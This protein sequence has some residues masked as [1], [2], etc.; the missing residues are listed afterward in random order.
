MKKFLLIIL[1][2]FVCLNKGNAQLM[3]A[4]TTDKSYEINVKLFPYKNQKLFIASYFGSMCLIIDSAQLDE[5]SQCVF[6]GTRKLQSGVY[7]LCDQNKYGVIDFLIGD[8]PFFTVNAD[9][10]DTR[11]PLIMYSN[12]TDNSRLADY[13]FFIKNKI[14]EFQMA[15][16]QL[17][18][19]TNQNEIAYIQTRL[20]G[21]NEE[22]KAKKISTLNEDPQSFVSKMLMAMYEPTL[23]DELQIQKN[24]KDSTKAKQYLSDHF[25]DGVDFW[26]TRLAYTPFFLPKVKKYFREIVSYKTDTI[27]KKIDWML[28]YAAASEDMTQLLLNDFI[29]ASMNHS[30]RWNDSVLIHLYEKYIGPKKYSWL[31]EGEV[32]EISQKAFYLMGKMIGSQ[33]PDIELKNLDDQL[34]SLYRTDSKFTILAFWDPTCHHCR[35]TLPKLDSMYRSTWKSKGV[36]VF[37]FAS[38]SDGKKVDWTNYIGEHHLENW[39]NVYCSN[40][41][42]ASQYNLGKKSYAQLYDV[43]YYPS[44]FVLDKAKRFVAKK[45]NYPQL[46][47]FLKTYLKQ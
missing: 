40:D 23:P 4:G 6:T 8:K 18:N 31:T 12:S 38:E 46:V 33:A 16:F 1:Y 36:N 27:I 43:W 32:N 29:K 44:F 19:A 7:T 2:F 10:S 5:N 21:V 37:A 17:E 42:N 11:N 14:K 13:N 26:D 9:I 39:T 28:S 35:E 3:N 20:K 22:I 34:I 24:E 25:W 45:L 47:D 30:Y 41:D 15:K